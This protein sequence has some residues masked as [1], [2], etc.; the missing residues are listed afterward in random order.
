MDTVVTCNLRDNTKHVGLSRLATQDSN[1]A[2]QVLLTKPLWQESWSLPSVE[3][4][5]QQL[6]NYGVL[7]YVYGSV[8]I[9]TASPST[10]CLPLAVKQ[11]EGHAQDQAA[12][13]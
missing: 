3:G 5:H 11:V 1:Q 7:W 4:H 10:V 9:R 12:G 6:C 13:P 8:V 2:M